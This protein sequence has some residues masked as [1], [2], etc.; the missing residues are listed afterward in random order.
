MAYVE[1]AVF[2]PKRFAVRIDTDAGVSGAYVTHWVGTPSSMAQA[3]MLAPL[4]LGRDP[5][6]REAIWIDMKREVRAYDHTEV[7]LKSADQ[8]LLTN[9]SRARPHLDMMHK[10]RNGFMPTVPHDQNA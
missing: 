8:S 2:T 4:M 7:R 9:V 10:K 5:N 3:T 1:G 6:Q